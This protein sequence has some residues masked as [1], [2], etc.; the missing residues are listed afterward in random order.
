MD[1]LPKLP[2]ASFSRARLA[3]PIA[4]FPKS[5]PMA[6]INLPINPVSLRDFRVSFGIIYFHFGITWS[7]DVTDKLDCRVTAE[8]KEYMGATAKTRRGKTCQQWTD[9]KVNQ[10]AIRSTHRRIF[11]RFTHLI[12]HDNAISNL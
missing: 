4:C 8:G 5:T 9:S 3:R 7:I 1:L 11:I 12:L 10:L 2:P 6:I